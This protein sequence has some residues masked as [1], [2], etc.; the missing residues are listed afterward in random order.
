MK[1]IILTSLIFAI[2]GAAQADTAYKTYFN[3]DVPAN[4]GS[5]RTA[6]EKV[7][8]YYIKIY[9]PGTT[10]EQDAKDL[11]GSICTSNDCLING[12]YWNAAKRKCES[13]GARLATVA[14]IRSL[15]EQGIINNGSVYT[16]DEYSA[17]RAYCYGLN[18]NGFGVQ[19]KSKNYL[20][21]FCIGE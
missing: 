2:C 18:S 1:K 15:R 7:G 19:S 14:E 8:D 11:T 3:D 6:P 17:D 12:D 13:Q 5:F 16:A 9:G 4:A 21:A 20:T 10:S